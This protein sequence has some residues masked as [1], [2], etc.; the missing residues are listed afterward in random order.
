MIEIKNLTFRYESRKKY[1]LHNVD[2][3]I[4]KGECVVLSGGSGSGKTSITRL[5]NGLIPNFYPGKIKGTIKVDGMD[6]T[7]MEPHQLTERVG[8]VFQN[9]RTQFFST[10]TDSELVFAMENCGLSRKDMEARYER[11]VKDL[12]LENLCRRNTEGLSGGEKQLIAFGSV[13]ALNPSIYVLDEPS[14]NL[15]IDGIKMLS[16]TIRSLKERG[17]TILIAEHRLYYLN[18]IADRVVLMEK[19]SITKEISMDKLNNLSD[20]ELHN[21]GLRTLNNKRAT[22]LKIDRNNAKN[23]LEI[24]QLSAAYGTNT[25]FQ[26]L[27]I[28]IREGEVVGVVG[29]NGK[30]KS[31]LINIICGA[32]KEKK[33][34]VMFNG[35]E[36]RTKARSR[37]AYLVMQD[38]NYQLFCDSVYAEL[39]LSRCDKS[40][41]DDEIYEV[42]EMLDLKEFRDMHPLSL[43]GGQKQRLAVGIAYLSNSNVLLFDE[44]TSGLDYRNMINVAK[45]IKNLA[46]KGKGILVISHDDEFLSQVCNH[47]VKI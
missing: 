41:S 46:N 3:N 40:F 28:S 42:M 13:Y 15:D 20:E 45:L 32:K 14:A 38:P 19:G 22:S 29:R 6:I 1:A 39:K 31:T 43:S 12:R 25:V 10:D 37:E 11:T 33:G 30:G 16:E 21:I 17:K 8:S 34:R 2:L 9:P 23:L 24:D 44:P 36:V 47:I 5:I 26:N 27:E 18:N 35:K 7:E 4:K